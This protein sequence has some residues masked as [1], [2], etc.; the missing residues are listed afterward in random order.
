[1]L[2]NKRFFLCNSKQNFVRLIFKNTPFIL[3]KLWF[4]VFKSSVWLDWEPNWFHLQP[5]WTA[6]FSK[7]RYTTSLQSRF[8]FVF[9]VFSTFVDVIMTLSVCR[10]ILEK[11]LSAWILFNLGSTS[12]LDLKLFCYATKTKCSET[13]KLLRNKK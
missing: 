13:A 1:M 11:I 3:K 2:I 4:I 10:I 8:N 7:R 9:L 6:T 12:L 5:H